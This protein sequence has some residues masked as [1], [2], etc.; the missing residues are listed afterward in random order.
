MFW[1]VASVAVS[2]NRLLGLGLRGVVIEARGVLSAKNLGIYLSHL[3]IFVKLTFWQQF[4]RNSYAKSFETLN[5]W[6]DPVIVY[7]ATLPNSLHE[8]LSVALIILWLQTSVLLNVVMFWY[9][10]EK[11]ITKSVS[12]F[13]KNYFQSYMQHFLTAIY[14]SKIDFGSGCW[15]SYSETFLYHPFR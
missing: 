7:A 8:Y 12:A 11:E 4:L 2:G 1:P 15:Y 6:F 10:G 9:A 14:P 13:A 3:W 5:L